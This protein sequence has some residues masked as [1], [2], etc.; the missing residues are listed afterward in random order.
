METLSIKLPADTEI[1]LREQAAQAGKDVVQYLSGLIKSN[2]PN[3]NF[4]LSHQ[5]TA[6]LEV[7]NRG[8]S[9]SFWQRLNLLD[10]KRRDEILTEDEHKELIFMAEQ[11]ESANVARISALA[12]LARL[13]EMDLDVLM[14]SLGIAHGNI[15]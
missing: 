4:V 12:G 13:R 11:V 10:A 6:L 1:L 3:K 8:F 2:T 9:E 14:E 5:E 7:I 15:H